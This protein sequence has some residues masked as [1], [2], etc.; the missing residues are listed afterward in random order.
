MIQVVSLEFAAFTA[1]VLLIYKFLPLTIQNVFLL[2]SSYI[3]ISTWAWEF[4]LLLLIYTIF[5]YGLVYKKPMRQVA[6]WLGII[7]SIGLL[8]FFGQKDFFLPRVETVLENIGLGS[9]TGILNLLV[10]LGLSYYVLQGIAYLLDVYQ[11]RLQPSRDPINFALYMAYFPKIVAGPIERADKF[12]PLLQESRSVSQPALTQSFVLIILGLVRKV[13][14]A[15][16]LT[17]MM[18]AELYQVPDQFSTIELTVYLLG[19]AFALYNDFAGYTE[20]VRGISGLFG[21][22]LSANFVHPYFSRSVTEF[23]QRWHITLSHWLRDYIYLPLART[24]LRRQYSREV[25]SLIPPIVTMLISGLWHGI[26]LHM[27]LWGGLHGLYLAW[28]R[29]LF[30]RRPASQR[31]PHMQ[32]LF[33]IMLTFTLVALAWVAFRSPSG[34]I[35]VDY[36]LSL[37]TNLTWTMPDVRV[38]ILV[39]IVLGIDLAQHRTQDEFVFLRWSHTLQIVLLALAILAIVLVAGADNS[40]PFVYQ[41]F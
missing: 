1:I 37:V 11:G 24:L 10:P 2:A 36:W 19:Y 31:K 9:D 34:H 38:F 7:F 35:A 22:P 6:L 13:V 5:C 14:I 3:F 30:L 21:I 8:I 17:T 32:Q 40:Q 33:G 23:W 39:G 12:L 4:A 25:S 41:G 18:P 27:L 26:N 29:W 15:D 16:S 20:I 28:E